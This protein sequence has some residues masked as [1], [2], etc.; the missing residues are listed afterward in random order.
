MR[1]PTESRP[2]GT[3][4]LSMIV[5][6]SRDHNEMYGFLDC[7]FQ[8]QVIIVS[9]VASTSLKAKWKVH[10]PSVRTVFR[11]LVLALYAWRFHQSWERTQYSLAYIL[12]L[13]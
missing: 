5:L 8:S 9:E 3:L 13:H 7:S 12:G 6:N 2:G 1:L 11:V 10:T 4:S